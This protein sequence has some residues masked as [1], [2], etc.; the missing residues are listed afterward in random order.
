[1]IDVIA[2]LP[3]KTG[4][5]STIRALAILGYPVM[6]QWKYFAAAMQ[7]KEDGQD[8]YLLQTSDEFEAVALP[9]L[10]KYVEELRDGHSAAKFIFLDRNSEDVVNSSMIHVLANRLSG[11]KRRAWR[12]LSTSYTRKVY[13]EARQKVADA[14]A[15]QPERLLMFDVRGGW[16]PLCEFLGR[17]APQVPFPHENSGKNHLRTVANHFGF[18]PGKEVRP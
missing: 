6:S 1:M 7:R 17:I 2:F 16:P 5:R 14:F 11:D 15:E 12:N 10:V 13:G 3:H 4:S 8:D 9:G 18:E